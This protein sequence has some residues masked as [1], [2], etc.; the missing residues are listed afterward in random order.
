MT[1]ETTAP[2]R[3]RGRPFGTNKIALAMRRSDDYAAA[4][5][6]LD[7]L[8]GEQLADFAHVVGGR[9]KRDRRAFAILKGV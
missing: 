7:K 4:I 8:E 1:A 2:K 3:P 9:V 6:A 5:A